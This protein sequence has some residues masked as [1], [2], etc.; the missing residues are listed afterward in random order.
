MIRQGAFTVAAISLLALVAVLVIGTLRPTPAPGLAQQA[1]ELESQLRCPDCQGLSIA[2][3]HTTSAGAIR[4]EIVTQLQAGRTPGQV[5]EYFISRYGQWILL[6]P[7][8]PLWL[9]I[10]FAVVALA[11]AGLVAWLALGRRRTRATGTEGGAGT[12]GDADATAARQRV[13]DE[14]EALDA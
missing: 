12:E 2:E 13:R 14:V 8:S 4:S 5:R 7:S 3:S 6:E 10:P 9:A 1:A 11:A